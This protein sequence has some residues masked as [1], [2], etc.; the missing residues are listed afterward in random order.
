M[1]YNILKRENNVLVLTKI[2]SDK[3]F[4]ELKYSYSRIPMSDTDT[5]N[6]LKWLKDKGEEDIVFNFMKNGKTE[7]DPKK[8]PEVL[9]SFFKKIAIAKENGNYEDVPNKVLDSDIPGTSAL[10]RNK[11]KTVIKIVRRRDDKTKLNKVCISNAI[12]ENFFRDAKALH[13]R[14]VS[15]NYCIYIEDGEAFYYWNNLMDNIYYNLYNKVTS[16][17]DLKAQITDGV[18]MCEMDSR[19]SLP[20]ARNYKM[21]GGCKNGTKCWNKQ[22]KEY[23]NKNFGTNY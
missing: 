8:Y 21:C 3:N 19:L 11:D 9:Q 13:G 2:P 1:F 5:E 17:K 12:R 22:N 23:L 14:P 16:N 10:L 7:I 20:Q 15:G 4:N 6:L 18:F